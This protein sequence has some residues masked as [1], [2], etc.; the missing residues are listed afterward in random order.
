MRKAVRSSSPTPALASAA[1][2]KE[3]G[4]S[5]RLL[6]LVV[7]FFIVGVIIGKIAL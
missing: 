5:A 6:A 4:L 7:L 3:E 2:G 1:T